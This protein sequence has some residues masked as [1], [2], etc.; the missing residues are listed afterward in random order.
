MTD[1][2]IRLLTTL[3]EMH[4]AVALQRSYWGEDPEAVVPG[5]MLLTLA[6]HGGHVLAAVDR[7]EGR[8]VAILVG[9][10]GIYPDA[11]KAA[12]RPYLVSKRMVVHADWRQRGLALRL[13][14]AQRE[15]ALAQGVQL[16]R[17]SFDPLLAPNAWLNLHKL[18]ARATQLH[19]DFFGA[20][21]PGGMASAGSPDRLLVDWQLDSERVCALAAGEDCDR[22]LVSLVE[23]GARLLNKTECDVRGLPLPGSLIEIPDAPQLLLELPP[24]FPGLAQLDADLAQDWRVH[25]RVALT[26]LF[27]VGHVLHDCVRGVLDGQDRLCYLSRRAERERRA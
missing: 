23:A 25:M 12:N 8:M 11:A 24:D 14:L 22:N 15:R 26:A 6:Q 10:P 9:L 18:G 27:A 5:H 2:D 17:W 3:P 7:A 4:E 1:V 20:E 16:V 13:K 21:G 19:E